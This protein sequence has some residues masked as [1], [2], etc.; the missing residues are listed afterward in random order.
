MCRVLLFPKDGDKP[1]FMW[2]KV[3]DDRFGRKPDMKAVM[4]NHSY[5]SEVIVKNPLTG[6]M[7]DHRIHLCYV[8]NFAGYYDSVNMAVV[9][10]ANG[11]CKP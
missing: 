5:R 11:M 6:V 9:G 2:L 1:K 10:A 3:V 4:D 7:L 8:E